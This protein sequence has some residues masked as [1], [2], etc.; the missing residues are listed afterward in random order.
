MKITQITIQNFSGLADFRHA[1]AARM[2]FVA[3]PNGAGKTSLQ[4]ALRFALT[5]ELARGVTKAADRSDL[6]TEGAASGFV[7]ITVDGIQVRRAI[8]SGKLMKEDPPSP[9]FLAHC[10][11]ATRFAQMPE[12][13][14][15][16]MLFELAGVRV[17]REVVAEQLREG[18]V[19][20][21][22]IERILPMLREGFPEAAKQ[23]RDKA[24]AKR[25]EWKGITG[26]NHGSQKALNWSPRVDGVQPTDAELDDVRSA[27][28]RS[29]ERVIEL[30]AAAGRAKG[31]VAP[32]RRV[33]L[34]SQADDL[35]GARAAQ[36]AKQTAYEE[37]SQAVAALELAARGHTS[38][39]HDC[40]SCGA[41][42]AVASDCTLTVA[43]GE[44]QTPART[45]K[46]LRAAKS[47]TE[48]AYT[49]LQQARARV[50]SANAARA[51]LDSLPG[52][53][54]ADDLA[55]PAELE[56][57]RRRQDVH[58]RT[59]SV[60]ETNARANSQAAELAERA[61]EA[62]EAL[63]SW[64]KA[65]TLLGPDGIPATLLARAL[66][67]INDAL[68]AEA[69]R[70]G[71]R[72]AQ[73]GRDLTMLYAGRPYAR[74]SESEQWRADALFAVVIAVMS[75][76]RLISLDRFDVLDVKERGQVIDWLYGLTEQAIETVIVTGT[77]KAAPALGDGIDV[78]WLGPKDEAA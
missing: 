29:E 46:E 41:R 59:L 11:D 66:D 74:C 1:V 42:L 13:D 67:P 2:L 72:P 55:A 77:L 40:P 31:G 53:P 4:Q 21:A 32:E 50:T 49:A 52:P 57:E 47:A 17:D 58:R 35:D 71:W 43:T 44:A 61:R 6:I 69:A 68:S 28:I 9:P 7:E 15:R 51:A 63:E 34:E 14:R 78:V 70:A 54:S 3:G 20:D 45:A 26:E 56:E 33:E 8:G 18:G 73:I 27:I 30:A 39:V 5:G 24:A 65:E 23:A 16:R 60:L 64:V 10:L 75:D 25:S 37:A 38:P 62:H 36:D 76:C 12:Q 22:A 48:T 19:S